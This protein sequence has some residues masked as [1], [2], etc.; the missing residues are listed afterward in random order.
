MPALGIVVIFIEFSVWHWRFDPVLNALVMSVSAAMRAYIFHNCLFQVLVMSPFFCPHQ[1][2]GEVTLDD[3]RPYFQPPRYPTDDETD[4]D[5]RL[6]PT[7]S[8]DSDPSEPSYPSYH[9]ETDPSEPSYS[10]M[11]RFT[12]N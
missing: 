2:Y 8:L 6:T 1:S 10:S 11:I 7:I 12:S 9:V 3:I 4:S 5:T